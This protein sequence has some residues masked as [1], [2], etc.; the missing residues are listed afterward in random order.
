MR[1]RNAIA[2]LLGV[3]VTAALQRS[4]SADGA[5]LGPKQLASTLLRILAY[6]RNL[7]ARS[8]GKAAPIFVLY[9]EG[10]Q[11]SETMQTDIVNALEDLASSVTVAELHA[12]VLAIPYSSSPDLEAKIMS[13]HPVAMFVCTGLADAVPVL[14]AAARRRSI[15]TLTLTT[16]YL[17]AGLSIGFER[18]DDRVNILIN[19]PASRAEGADLDAALL[20]LAEVYR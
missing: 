13:R 7:K 8:G 18:G 2:A 16:A 4:G 15:L 17:K 14:S 6:D 1:R 5:E 3:T 12:S 9:Q 20:R 11:A 10:N 19:L